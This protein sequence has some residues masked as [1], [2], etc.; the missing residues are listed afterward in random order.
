MNEK[1]AN[2]DP[3][4]HCA[5]IQGAVLGVGLA[6]VERTLSEQNEE[7]AR[8]DAQS[9]K[10]RKPGA[11][12]TPQDSDDANDTPSMF[13]FKKPKKEK[14]KGGIGYAGDQK[15]DVRCHS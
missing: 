10:R 7:A 11:T 13:S 2:N 3:M 12:G 8:D 14:N 15:E 5:N 1:K 6:M 9:N 4:F